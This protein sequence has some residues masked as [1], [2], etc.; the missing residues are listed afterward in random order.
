VQ[1]A[2]ITK[3]LTVRGGYG[4]NFAV[5][6]PQVYPTTLDAEGEGHVI[7]INGTAPG[8]IT[9]TL[10]ALHVTGGRSSQGGAGIY[11]RFAD[12]VIS[13][14][15]VYGNTA[16]QNQGGGLF[17]EYGP[18]ARL[19][20]NRIHGNVAVT[21]LSA[22]GGGLYLRGCDQATLAG[23][24]LTRNEGRYGGGAVL[25]DSDATLLN[26]V[27][28]D[29]VAGET[30][31]GLYVLFCSPR[32]LHTTIARNGGGGDGSGVYVK[33]GTTALTN[34]VLVGHAVGVSITAGATAALEST[35]WGAGAWAN[36]ADWGGVGTVTST[37]GYTGA[38]G[39]VDPDGGDYHLAMGS[40]AIDLGIDAGV[41][42]D[43]DGES[44][45]G[46]PDLGADELVKYDVYLPLVLRSY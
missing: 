29:N 14:C 26:N 11:S 46:V 43:L 42:T 27:F 38:P 7:V 17:V 23:N 13:G 4:Q 44:R 25:Y 16:T 32:L 19:T 18:R 5:W 2:Y 21:G 31:G 39:F 34:T 41:L 22:Y 36:G 15:H 45:T 28:A 37:R 1:L 20:A 30:G 35:L 6:D 24:R 3:T 10:E 12:T 9:P 8:S 40:A 33:N